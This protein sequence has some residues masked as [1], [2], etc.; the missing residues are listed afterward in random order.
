[1]LL[2]CV[3]LCTLV[4]AA[5]A[6]IIYTDIPDLAVTWSS[7]PAAL[8]L[9]QDGSLDVSVHAY[10]GLV[11]AEASRPGVD[12]LTYVE[13]VYN[14][15]WA[16]NVNALELIGTTDQTWQPFVWIGYV[17]SDDC[18]WLPCY[19][20]LTYLDAGT[21]TFM[22][23]RLSESDDARYAWVR[24]QL[25]MWGLG[26]VQFQI[27]DFA[28]ETTPDLPIAAGNRC[29][30]GA[31]CNANS[32][33][34]C[35]EIV[36]DP[37]LDCNQNG[38]LDLCEL[39]LDPTLDCDVDGVI[40]ACQLAADPTLDCNQNGVLDQCE[41]F[42]DPTLDCNNDGLIDACQFAA[43]PALDCNQN[44]VLDLCEPPSDPTLDCDSDGMFDACQFSPPFPGFDDHVSFP[45]FNG[46]VRVAGLGAAMPRDEITI[47]LWQ[48]AILA[49]THTT[50]AAAPQNTSDRVQAH[51]PW[52]DGRVY[53]DFGSDVDG[54]LSYVP[55]EPIT[56]SWQ[57][58]AF[59]A[60]RSGNFMRIYRNGVLE[61]ERVGFE[62][63]DGT[64]P[65]FEI[66]GYGESSSGWDFYGSI[67]EFRIWNIARSGA[68]IAGD[69]RRRV[70]PLTPGLV[71]YYRLD[72]ASGTTTEDL[73]GGRDG[74]LLGSV[75]W[76]STADCPCLDCDGDA[77]SDCDEI[78]G[79]A[80]DCDGNYVPDV[81]DLASDPS[82]DC[83]ANGQLDVCQIADPT[84]DCNANGRLDACD[85]GDGASRDC[86]GNGTPDECQPDS[87]PFRGAAGHL[88]FHGGYDAVRVPGLGAAM[89][90]DEI[91]IEFWQWI[92]S[93][94]Q[95][96]TFT[97]VPDDPQN[98]VL[99]HTPWADGRVYW[100]FGSA[101][102]PGRL[103]YTPPQSL[104]GTWQHFA[105]VASRSGHFMRI[106]RNGVLEAAREDLNDGY[107]GTLDDF[108]IGNNGDGSGQYGF[109]GEIDEFRIWSVARSSEQIA[110]HY[111]RR[112]SPHAPG[113]VAYYRFD[114]R[115][116]LTTPDLAGDHDGSL[117]GPSWV[118][119][120]CLAVPAAPW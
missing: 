28:Y 119:P 86:D 54:R 62:G 96:T 50:F 61:A 116:G 38:V 17:V 47:E 75:V 81:C 117:F 36:A 82:R 99:A 112:V 95:R 51:T 18:G 31:D 68:E 24:V 43:D 101:S 85:I 33:D 111:N 15:N 5:R 109:V 83:D 70:D 20:L 67:D 55:P 48:F 76:V 52:Q 46:R 102:G 94:G 104:V 77:V 37:T 114:N 3:W 45:N 35:A 63:Y 27:F 21:P 34:D 12:V 100:D 113:L 73:S 13:P 97:L 32:I 88:S 58:F 6:E 79:G 19:S 40:D 11:W 7:G 26:V 98:R 89:P 44:G 90:T 53:W 39:F 10:N 110:A 22:G 92:P 25:D 49:T 23:V 60:S 91:T 30:A 84:L 93:I 120:L 103:D 71:A 78:A 65:D 72:E 42:L 87:A 74:S 118:T 57:H 14:R 56:G 29:V 2:H 16:E 1:M 4:S 69:Y 105:F 115:V 80:P 108:E 66:G 8:D 106:Y 64:S 41:L 9:D 107:D 59:V